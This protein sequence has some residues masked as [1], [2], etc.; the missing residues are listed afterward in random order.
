MR[1]KEIRHARIKEL[2]LSDRVET[3]EMLAEAL[4]KIGIEVSQSTLSKDLRELGVVRAPQT[5][6]RLRYTVPETGAT[7][8][9]QRVLSRDLLDYMVSVERAG[10]LVVLKT[11]SGRA[12]GV[13]ETL[14]RMEW[15]EIIGTLGLNELFSWA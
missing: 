1:S 9:D 14:D 6:G 12:Q 3:H 11:M 5:D 10:H 15:P 8:R 4:E 2:L 7:F 13:C